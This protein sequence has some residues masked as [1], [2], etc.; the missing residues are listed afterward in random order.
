MLD[1]KLVMDLKGKHGNDLVAVQ[2][3]DGSHL[4]FRKP[5]RQEYDRWFDRRAEN[6]S[7]AARELAQ[8]TLVY[9]ERDG[10]MAVLDAQPAL[11]MC[12]NGI[13]DAVTELAGLG[14]DA[15]AKKL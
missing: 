8:S 7:V 9:P 12:K 1:E 15:V 11:L 4:I 13:L 10:M 2:C 6:G 3:H 14:G 5:K